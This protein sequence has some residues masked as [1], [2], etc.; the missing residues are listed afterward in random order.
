VKLERLN[1]GK[2]NELKAQLTQMQPQ[3]KIEERGDER[4]NRRTRAESQ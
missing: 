2:K 3:Q 4:T 1:D